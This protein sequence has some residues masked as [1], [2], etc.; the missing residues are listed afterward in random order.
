MQL[1]TEQNVREELPDVTVLFNGAR[2]R[3]ITSGRKNDFATV[4]PAGEPGLG[5]GQIPHVP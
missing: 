2:I 5:R 1:Q 4:R 3:C